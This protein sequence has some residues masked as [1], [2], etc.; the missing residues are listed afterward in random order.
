MPKGD[1]D[2]PR[3]AGRKDP[4]LRTLGDTIRDGANTLGMDL[5]P[6]ADWLR[7]L[8]GAKTRAEKQAEFS[9]G[10]SMTGRRR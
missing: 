1:I 4:K 3:G 10:R 2:L 9:K 5:D 6:R 7:K 8:M